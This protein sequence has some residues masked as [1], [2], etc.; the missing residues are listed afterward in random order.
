MF[1]SLVPEMIGLILTPLAIIC[2]ILLLESAK[3]LPNSIAFGLGFFVIYS[4]LC[5]FTL[6]I[7]G[8]AGA[9]K[10]DSDAAAVIGIVVGVLFLIGGVFTWIRKPVAGRRPKWAAVIESCTPPKAFA[11]GLVLAIVNPNI[12]ILLSG[13]SIVITTDVGAGTRIA[14]A[15]CLVFASALDFLIPIGIYLAMGDRAPVKLAAL[16]T[17][18]LA[19]SRAISIG[20]LL[21]LGVVFVVRGIGDLG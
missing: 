6:V 11:L 8:A 15:A 18:M 4:I 5:I 10:N 3:P 7:G 1:V 2:C 13:L 16:R 14:G 17:W 9:H 12:M 20:M 21:V 19:K